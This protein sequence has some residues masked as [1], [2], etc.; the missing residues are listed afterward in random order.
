M[1][2][3][4]QCLRMTHLVR[5]ESSIC[6]SP[7]KERVKK[8]EEDGGPSGHHCARSLMSSSEPRNKGWQPVPP[9]KRLGLEGCQQRQVENKK[10]GKSGSPE[11]LE[12]L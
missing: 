5:R 7:I 11:D 8:G 2:S 10:A 4:G 1:W 12:R 3:L 9:G 6:R